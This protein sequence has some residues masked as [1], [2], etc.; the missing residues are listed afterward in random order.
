MS[1]HLSNYFCIT[2]FQLSPSREKIDHLIGNY[3]DRSHSMFLPPTK[4]SRDEAIT[5][6]QAGIVLFIETKNIKSPILRIITVENKK[7]LRLDGKSVPR[8]EL[9]DL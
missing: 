9:G 4:I 1:T 6:I 3:T 5:M 8:D 2:G 7:Y